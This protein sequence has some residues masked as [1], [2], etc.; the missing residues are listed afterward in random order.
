[1]SFRRLLV[2]VGA[3][4]SIF[5]F[6][7][8]AGGLLGPGATDGSYP[9][10]NGYELMDTGGDGTSIVYDGSE[11]RNWDVVGERVDAY[12]VVGSNL[13]V[14]RRPRECYM[15]KDGALECKLS[16]TCEYWAVDTAEHTVQR[17][18]D[19]GGLHCK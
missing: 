2:V 17:T 15:A 4:L 16:Q 6:L 19:S 8:L 5:A 14:A 11:N 9:I 13:I 7:I 12:A 1:M 18:A 10:M 3:S